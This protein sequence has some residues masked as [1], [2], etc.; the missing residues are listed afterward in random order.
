[1]STSNGVG[2]GFEEDGATTFHFHNSLAQ[3]LSLLLQRGI[4]IV[5]TQ[6]ISDKRLPKPNSKP[7]F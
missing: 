2:I 7:Q 3:L 4:G 6:E 1:M 5:T